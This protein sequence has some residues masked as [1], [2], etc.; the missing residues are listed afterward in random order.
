MRKSGF[1]W[2]NEDIALTMESMFGKAKSWISTFLDNNSCLHVGNIDNQLAS[3]S[4]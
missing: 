1:Q 3:H 4:K 2:N